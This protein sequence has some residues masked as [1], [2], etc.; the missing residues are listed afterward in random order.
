MAFLIVLPTKNEVLQCTM[1]NHKGS[2]IAKF[3]VAPLI[4]F[5][6][7]GRMFPTSAASQVVNIDGWVNL[8]NRFEELMGGSGRG[9][10][11]II[12]APKTWKM[13]ETP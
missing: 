9:H 7:P 2:N 12:C 13:W 1:V 10:S 8:L 5:V 3:T 6:L 4:F 11:C